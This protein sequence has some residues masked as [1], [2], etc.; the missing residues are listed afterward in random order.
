VKEAIELTTRRTAPSSRKRT[1]KEAAQEVTH[2]SL[3][4]FPN[5]CLT[6]LCWFKWDE[7]EEEDEEDEDEDEEDS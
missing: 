5:I 3:F 1:R 2:A 6:V 7:K 4:F